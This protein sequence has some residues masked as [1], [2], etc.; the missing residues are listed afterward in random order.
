MSNTVS[1]SFPIS[2][3][4]V[5]DITMTWLDVTD[6]IRKNIITRPRRQNGRLNRRNLRRILRRSHLIQHEH[7]TDDLQFQ[8]Q[9]FSSMHGLGTSSIMYA[10]LCN[11]PNKIDKFSKKYSFSSSEDFLLES[12]H[13]WV[14]PLS[15]QF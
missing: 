7:Q 2:A 12:L 15:K 4:T 5:I 1:K 3:C 8:S 6:I 14:C 11:R 10:S 9:H 13:R